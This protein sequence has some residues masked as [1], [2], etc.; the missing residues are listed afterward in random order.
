VAGVREQALQIF[1]DTGSSDAM[2]TVL[3]KKSKAVQE[4]QTGEGLGKPLP[5]MVGRVERLQMGRFELRN[6]TC[7][8]DPDNENMIGGVVLRHFVATFDYSRKRII[9]EKAKHFNDPF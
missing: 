6:S 4:A 7:S 8:G 5:G 3:L 2:D 9:L 1:V